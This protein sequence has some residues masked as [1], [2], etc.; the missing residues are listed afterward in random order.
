MKGSSQT[1]RC[2]HFQCGHMAV[3]KDFITNGEK[4]NL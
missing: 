3:T 4:V 1:V 2:L